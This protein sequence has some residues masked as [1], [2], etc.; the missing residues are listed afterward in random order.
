MSVGQEGSIDSFLARAATRCG[1]SRERY[2]AQSVPNSSSPVVVLPFFGDM[3]AEV[4]LACLVA[5]R[6][7]S[8]HRPGCYLIVA[9]W[10]GH[11]GFWPYA[12]EF[13]GLAEEPAVVQAYCSAAG[14]RSGSSGVGNA[15]RRL[16]E[17]FERCIEV[18]DL[19]RY[20]S[21]GFNSE[22]FSSFGDPIIVMPPVRPLPAAINK[23]LGK[24]MGNKV[25]ISPARVATVYENGVLRPQPIDLAFWVGL[26]KRL[27]SDG[28]SPVVWQGARTHDV[29]ALASDGCFYF[30]T[31]DVGDALSAMRSC[32]VVVDCF[33]DL[34]RMAAMARCPYVVAQDRGK[35]V[36]LNDGE[37]DDVLV[38]NKRRKYFFTASSLLGSRDWGMIYDAL[39]VHIEGVVSGDDRRSW[40]AAGERREV[41][42]VARIRERRGA[43][44]GIHFLKMP[45]SLGV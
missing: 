43:K 41:I 5:H 35:F 17:I 13:W 15:F 39:M 33:G 40:P 16:F 8:M 36:G 14:Y 29:S 37:L 44:F 18:E 32:D 23:G 21:A 12:D 4:I 42:P 7:V 22:F 20:Y 38:E 45:K 30:A 3:R 28:Y 9:S 27:V 6:Y 31:E 34:H 11:A 25:F 24:V 2:E 26:V 10:P 19:E 1:F